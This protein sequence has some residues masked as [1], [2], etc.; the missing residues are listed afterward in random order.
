MTTATPV[1][2][3]RFVATREAKDEDRARWV[4][5][6]EFC[7]ARPQFL[8]YVEQEQP[9]L[10]LN[11]VSGLRRLAIEARNDLWRDPRPGFGARPEQLLP[12]TEGSFS[13]RTD[14]ATWLIQGGRGS[15]K[16]R[17]AAE[18]VVELLFGREWNSQTIRVALVGQT[19]ESVR[20][21]MVE[22]TLLQCLPQGVRIKWNRSICELFIDLPN[23]KRAYLKGYSSDAARKLRGPNFHLAWCD[24]IATWTDADRSPNAPST[25][26][27]NM[28]LAVR[29]DDGGGWI[30]RVIAT[31]TPKPIRLIR[32]YEDGDQLNPGKGVYDDPTTV[33]SHMSTLDNRAN[34]SP[35]YYDTVVKPLEG[36]RLYEQEVMGV[37]VDEVLGALWT[38]ELIEEMTYIAGWPHAQ[39][40][41]I[42]DI[43]IGVDPSV[44]AGLGAE[45]GIVVVGLAADGN[46]YILRDASI[47]GT[48][49][50]WC[51]HL[52]Q[53][54]AE[55][56]ASLVIVEANHG[57]DLLTET[58][59][60][61]APGLPIRKVWA[62]VGKTLRAEPAALLSDQGRLRFAQATPEDFP[63]LKRQMR[64]WTGEGESPDR[65]DAMVYAALYL[66]KPYG[67]VSP[68]FTLAPPGRRQ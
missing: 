3:V 62:K 36:T 49:A 45:C 59:G 23:G 61:H 12:G 54:Y 13:D 8:P 1:P 44:G 57:D 60:R 17:T 34:L 18:T 25:T 16:S 50:E 19:L 32:N 22:N 43:V 21:D 14:W 40:G 56:G 33:V 31:T 37:L 46:A 24:E 15:G 52:A 11:L 47:R 7:R 29:L 64:T 53:V 51:R 58:L 41:G 63:D 20:I 66:I 38:S 10:Y 55:T 5:L 4:A 2:Q 9:A 6:S 26:W 30:P 28:K 67:D 68:L 48:A 35:H 39:G 65:L 27:S 42:V